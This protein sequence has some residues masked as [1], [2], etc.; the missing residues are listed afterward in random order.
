MIQ[1]LG[2]EAPPSLTIGTVFSASTYFNA[3]ADATTQEL[4]RTSGMTSMLLY[5][6]HRRAPHVVEA[7]LLLKADANAADTQGITP[8]MLA[9]HLN[10]STGTKMVRDILRHAGGFVRASIVLESRCGN[11]VLWWRACAACFT[12]ALH[13]P[14]AYMHRARR[15]VDP[16]AT[17]AMDVVCGGVSAFYIAA[18]QGHL[19]TLQT[20]VET[21]RVNIVA[22]GLHASTQGSPRH[23]LFVRPDDDPLKAHLNTPILDSS[24][25]L[26][27][28]VYF[29]HIDIVKFLLAEGCSVN[30]EEDD[31]DSDGDESV[32]TLSP[33]S[34]G[35]LSPHNGG[36]ASNA[37]ADTRSTLVSFNA[38]E[39]AKPPAQALAVRRGHLDVARVL[40]MAGA[41]L[42]ATYGPHVLL[43]GQQVSLV[44]M[45]VFHGDM[46]S[47]RTL[48]ELGAD[49][50]WTP[51]ADGF[52]AAHFA[53]LM[54][55]LEIL[56]FLNDHP[57]VR[58]NESLQRRTAAGEDCNGL[59]KRWYQVKL[60]HAL[61]IDPHML[62]TRNAKALR[63]D[64]Q[65][66]WATH[67]PTG[68]LA[69]VDDMHGII[70]SMDIN[71]HFPMDA[72]LDLFANAV[73]DDVFY[74]LCVC[75]LCFSVFSFFSSIGL[76]VADYF[77][78]LVSQTLGC[79]L[80][81]GFSV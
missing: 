47:L 42:D 61:R 35:A 63:H 16:F 70:A 79:C 75:V 18:Q 26:L 8:L 49:V 53:A 66:A 41:S 15:S 30:L 21:T 1:V 17:T 74:V 77:F 68:R 13:T 81:V 25:P 5:A 57:K 3:A 39:A 32:G 40:M 37:V 51:R 20:M 27:V 71:L 62:V 29:G 60:K 45:A 24:T 33:T 2:F 44:M 23:S 46:T 69:S 6:V 48:I 80:L 22:G 34:T 12:L 38:V 73:R 7:L 10:D 58:V 59:M 50:S 31:S 78:A 43:G 64:A 9:A 72:E 56:N 76:Y 28:A 67:C 4:I 36:G 52:N 55:D 65:K 14:F 54:F 19:Q 11:C